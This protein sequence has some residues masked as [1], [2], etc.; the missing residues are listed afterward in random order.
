V[1][2]ANWL[3]LVSC[4]V[5]VG[6]GIITLRVGSRRK[7]TTWGLSLYVGFGPLLV[8]LPLGWRSLSLFSLPYALLIVAAGA[9]AI[10]GIWA[11]AEAL[12]RGPTGPTYLLQP[13]SLAIPVGGSVLLYHE[14]LSALKVAGLVTVAVAAVLL[15]LGRRRAGQVSVETGGFSPAWLVYAL[16]AFLFFGLTGLI[17]RD[18]AHQSGAADFYL[19]V[20]LLAYIGNMVGIVGGLLLSRHRP[21]RDDMV[22][23]S[24]T[25][26]LNF[27]GFILGMFLMRNIGGVLAFPMRYIISTLI[28][29]LV[30]ALMLRERPDARTLAGLIAGCGGVLLLSVA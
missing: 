13:F 4:A 24:L 27:G 26:F 9:L 11:T 23:G 6:L 12:R 3:L 19:G 1:D 5:V 16:M 8:A 7:T 29:V 25:G 21:T 2:I 15:S 14:P 20:V 17:L 18:A 22:W 10:V 28:V 30:A